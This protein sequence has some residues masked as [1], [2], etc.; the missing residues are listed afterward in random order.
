MF[1]VEC[2]SKT[3]SCGKYSERVSNYEP[4]IDEIKVDDITMPMRIQ[5]MPK[6]EKLN[7]LSINVY[8]SDKTGKNIWPIYI[9]K[10][11]GSDPINLLL[12]S[13]GEKSHYTWIND[14]NALLG[15]GTP[16][17]KAVLSKLSAWVWLENYKLW[18]DE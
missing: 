10:R 8:M 4:Y 18:E 5:Q 16:P 1:S 2:V 14:F 17:S 13:D 11:R 15:S 9:S 3:I 6:F 7:E 12:L